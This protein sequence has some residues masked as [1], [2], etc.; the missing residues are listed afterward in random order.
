[1]EA[2]SKHR[3]LLSAL[4]VSIAERGMNM[5]CTSFRVSEG[6]GGTDF[7]VPKGSIGFS[8]PPFLT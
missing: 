8:G 3:R 2:L 5:N 7:R 1:M 6:M 4:N